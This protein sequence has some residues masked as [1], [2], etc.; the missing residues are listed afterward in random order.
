VTAVVCQ[1]AVHATDSVP[2][3]GSNSQSGAA[4][5][6]NSRTVEAC[7]QPG[8]Q[9]AGYCFI[10]LVGRPMSSDSVCRGKRRVHSRG[11]A[12]WIRRMAGDCRFPRVFCTMLHAALL[13]VAFVCHVQFQIWGSAISCVPCGA[14]Q[15]NPSPIRPCYCIY[16]E[17]L[18]ALVHVQMLRRTS[19]PTEDRLKQLLGLLPPA[20]ARWLCRLTTGPR[21]ES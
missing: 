14:L 3:S 16:V 20:R 18:S 15:M 17:S 8:S 10:D 9:I 1:E 4:A 6:W 11:L 12:S 2:G 21:L 13:L 7:N 5:A 19:S